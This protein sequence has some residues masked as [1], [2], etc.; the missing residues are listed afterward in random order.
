M[1]Q[2]PEPTDF[3]VRAATQAD[4]PAV[5]ALLQ[6][7]GLP[8]QDLAAP[9]VHLLVAERAG[10][11]AGVVGL[12][13]CGEA[14]LLRSLAVDARLRGAGLG[15][16]LAQQAERCAR[17]RGDRALWLLT[18]DAAGF[19]AARGYQVA[20]RAQAPSAIQASAQFQ[21]LCPASA[22]CMAKPL[23]A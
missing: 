20:A 21:T 14:S 6:Q 7:A 22:T 12:Q 15:S 23:R 2:P 9:A 5:L 11:L 19:F 13:A 18:A 16:L 1:P 10:Q 17:E 3:R 8:H 4:R